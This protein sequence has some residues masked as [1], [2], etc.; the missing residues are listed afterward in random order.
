MSDFDIIL[1]EGYG[2]TVVRLRVRFSHK[3]KPFPFG[4]GGQ[5]VTR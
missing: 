2:E 3:G 1:D 5:K 4:A